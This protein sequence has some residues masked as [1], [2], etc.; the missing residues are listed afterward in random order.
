MARLAIRSLFSPILRMIYYFFSLWFADGPASPT[1][2]WPESVRGRG[3]ERKFYA[4]GRGS[5]CDAGR[6]QPSGERGRRYA[7]DESVSARAATGDPHRGGTRL[8]VGHPLC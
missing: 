1:I 5:E 6:R 7:R 2:E 8:S 3:S 4:R